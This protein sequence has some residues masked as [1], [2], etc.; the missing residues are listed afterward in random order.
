MVSDQPHSAHNGYQ[1]KSP[2]TVSRSKDELH[3]EDLNDNKKLWEGAA[4]EHGDEDEWLE[5]SEIIHGALMEPELKELPYSG[6]VLEPKWSEPKLSDLNEFGE[7]A[8]G[9]EQDDISEHAKSED[10]FEAR[11][12]AISEVPTV[13]VNDKKEDPRGQLEVFEELSLE[14]RLKP[15]NPKEGKVKKHVCKGDKDRKMMPPKI[16]RRNQDVDVNEKEQTWYFTW[17]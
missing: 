5:E 16:Q 12:D 1:Q 10:A 15:P 13:P 7:S 8:S 4:G 9:F 2:S 17:T 11:E 3:Y 14:G 6:R